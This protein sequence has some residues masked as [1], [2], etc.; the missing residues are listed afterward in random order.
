MSTNDEYAISYTD[1]VEKGQT[2]RGITDRKDME[3]PKQTLLPS[4]LLL[5]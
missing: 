2:G 4:I 1:L 3:T 5:H